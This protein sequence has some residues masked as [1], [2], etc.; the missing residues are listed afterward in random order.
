MYSV[1]IIIGCSLLSM[2]DDCNRDLCTVV[3]AFIFI[4]PF[5]SMKKQ[6]TRISLIVDSFRLSRSFRTYPSTR[7]NCVTRFEKFILAAREH[8]KSFPTTFR[9]K[10]DKNSCF[11]FAVFDISVFFSR[12][13][14]TRRT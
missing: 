9:L 5:C 3:L 2:N 4:V 12:T 1:H 8:A 10:F 11:A 7:G 6:P 14:P 13:K